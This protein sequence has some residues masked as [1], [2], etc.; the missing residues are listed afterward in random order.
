MKPVT[1]KERDVVVIEP[2]GSLCEGWD[3]SPLPGDVMSRFEGGDRRFLIDLS[4]V[5]LINFAGIGVLVALA[6]QVARAGGEFR[7]SSV[8]ERTQRALDHTGLGKVLE[9]YQTMEEGLRAF[10]GPVLGPSSGDRAP[11][12]A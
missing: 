4:A 11:R 12:V 9:V 7:I 1:R 5:R 6:C 2:A 8:G 10:E 3:A